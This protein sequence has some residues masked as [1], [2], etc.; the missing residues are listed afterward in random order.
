MLTCAPANA[1]TM[2][3]D[4]LAANQ[5]GSIGTAQV[6]VCRDVDMGDSGQTPPACASL[7]PLGMATSPEEALADMTCHQAMMTKLSHTG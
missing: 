6:H 3:L 4:V 2:P 5:I 7:G 1:T